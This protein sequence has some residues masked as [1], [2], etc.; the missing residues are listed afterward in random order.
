MAKIF[1]ISKD[2]E[3]KSL[4][5]KF[6]SESRFIDYNNKDTFDFIEEI[7]NFRPDIII[8]D[9][10]Y[11]SYENF[12]KLGKTA[13]NDEN[14]QMVLALHDEDK[15]IDCMSYVDGIIKFPIDEDILKTILNSHMKTK[16]SFDKLADNNKELSKSLYQINAL[17]N[18]SSQ[19]AGTL[20]KDDLC[21]IMLEGLNRI[22]SF[23]IASVLILGQNKSAVLHINSLCEISKTLM[24]ALKMRL[25]LKYNN[26][27]EDEKIPF[28]VDFRKI[29]IVEKTKPSSNIYDLKIL[30]YNTLFA[31]IKVGDNFFG[32][33]E[34][35]KKEPFSSEDVTC[36]QT[37]VHQVAL[38]LRS[39][40]LYEEIK[41]TN[42]KLEKLEKIKS[43]FVSVVSHELRTPL[44]PINN[45]LEIVLSGQAGE[46]SD[47]TKN[48]INMAKRNVIRLSGIIED[49]LDLSRVQT[50]KLEYKFKKMNIKP[51]IDLVCQTFKQ[52]AQEK[53][54]NFEE[55]IEDDLGEY[56]ID[57]RRIEQILS[58]IIS[59][60]LKFT[61]E[62]GYIK[63][64][65]KKNARP[66]DRLVSPVKIL[67]NNYLKISIEDSGVGIKEEDIPKIFDKFSQVESSLARNTG[68]IG[69]G[70][71]ITKQLLDTHFGLVSVESEKDKGSVFNIYIPNYSQEINF[72]MELNKTILKAP[73][74]GLIY[75]RQEKDC[76]FIQKLEEKNIIKKTQ[77]SME[78]TIPQGNYEHYF[79]YIPRLED[80]ALNFIQTN[81]EQE[82]KNL[83]TNSENCNILLETA[84]KT[85]MKKLESIIGT[86]DEL[87]DKNE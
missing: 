41:E 71:T 22:L 46:I 55:N 15:N 35:I 80:S 29:K 44:T 11:D 77:N 86:L 48:F 43:E 38:P 28:E 3:F 4:A 87:G 76:N 34:I 24:H 59:N 78:I 31:P 74:L 52:S 61:S 72:R 58:N 65:T 67:D 60:A 70:L 83:K 30:N 36:F 82:I 20:N 6:S 62:K 69:L 40:T 23:D 5:S 14:I 68:G 2:E 19:F 66:D 53:N 1:V 7:K 42:I 18:T 26:S 32:V 25:T 63:V 8:V 56:Y 81:I 49:L 17:Y 12:I 9:S 16:R 84:T 13:S 85:D 10:A 50:G 57:N 73:N 64:T 21:N 79:I 37:I 27:F 47:D 54:I 39:A 45:S 51:S 75:I 33:I